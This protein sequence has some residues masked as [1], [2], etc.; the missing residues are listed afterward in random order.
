MEER[1]A[2]MLNYAF[3]F[4]SGVDTIKMVDVVLNFL[5]LLQQGVLEK[6]RELWGDD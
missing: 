5:L 3:V 1:E 2:T 6:Q 4:T